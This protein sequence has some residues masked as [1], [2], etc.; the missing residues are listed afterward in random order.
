[1]GLLEASTS[2]LA[3]RVFG[4]HKHKFSKKKKFFFM[5]NNKII[6]AIYIAQFITI[7][8]NNVQKK[9]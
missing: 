1:M 5:N 6:F 7:M 2:L 4:Y 9:S 8:Y 3:T